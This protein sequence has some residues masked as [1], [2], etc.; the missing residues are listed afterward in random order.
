[1]K[2]YSFLFMMLLVAS[3]VAGV[4]TYVTYGIYGSKKLLYLV[5]LFGFLP[6]ITSIIG[7]IYGRGSIERYLGHFLFYY[8]YIAIFSIGIALIQG[9]SLLFRKNFFEYIR[10]NIFQFNLTIVLVILITAIYGKY[11]FEKVTEVNKQIKIS[12]KSGREN[13]N[14]GFI[15][16]VHLN[17]VFDGKKL[18]YALEKM[19]NSGADLVIIG[20]DLIDN[21][22]SIIAPGIKE[23]IEKYN[24]THG[25]HTILGN[26]EYYGG[27]EKN[28]DYI[29]GIGIN[30]LRDDILKIGNV[31]IIGRDDRMNRARKSLKDFMEEISLENTVIVV[32]H[33]PITL[34]ESIENSVD[35]HL[36]G[37]TH[38][39][40]LFPMN[41]VVDFI[42]LNGN[43]YK[44]F[45][46]TH[47]YVSSG[48]GT[49]MIP[50]R[51]G[52]QSQYVM[53]EIVHE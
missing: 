27:I 20:G 24:F 33:N 5:P 28:M 43:G 32:D 15:S 47:S 30:I 42:N 40:Q 50:Y 36:S 8:N 46:D 19:K 35:L 16:D 34:P 4:T 7:R 10:E 37:H 22:S 48:L 25:I 21:D 13:L 9:F 39:G 14:I 3:A 12:G 6:F 1:M 51:V 17:R 29:K 52:S 11:K 2:I 45:N 53:L 18:D 31:S 44:K 26:H 41:L 49:W 23:I 38:N